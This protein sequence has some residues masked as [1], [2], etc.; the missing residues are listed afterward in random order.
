[1]ERQDSRFSGT[2][3]AIGG[4][5]HMGSHIGD[6]DDMT[7]IPLDHLGRKLLDCLEWAQAIDLEFAIELI[8]S[9]V[10]NQFAAS[11]TNTVESRLWV[12]HHPNGFWISHL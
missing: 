5:N 8:L 11:N 3:T 6:G 1:M 2:V 4:K 7:V 10:E 9:F 12:R